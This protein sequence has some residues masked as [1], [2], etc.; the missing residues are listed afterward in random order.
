MSYIEELL[1]YLNENTQ[2]AAILGSKVMP[3]VLAEG[4]IFPC[5]LYYYSRETPE[6]CQGGVGMLDSNL[7]FYVLS[8]RYAQVE[9]ISNI[10]KEALTTYKTDK[11][12]GVE[13]VS[14]SSEDYLSEAKVFQRIYEFRFFIQ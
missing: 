12:L 5:I 3:L 2:L 11:V 10:L 8:K 14:L 6:Y 9:E 1:E 7:H 13:Y 4:E